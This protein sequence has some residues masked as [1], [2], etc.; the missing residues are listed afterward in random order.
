MFQV[1]GFFLAL[2]IVTGALVA[3]KIAVQENLSIKSISL[4]DLLPWLLIPGLIGARVYHVIDYWNYYGQF[5]QEIFYFWQG[6]L[7]IFGALAGGALGMFFFAR[8]QKMGKKQLLSLLDISGI[9]LSLG[10]SIG[11]WGNFFNQELYGQPTSLPWGIYIKPE[12]RL[13]EVAGF[14]FFHPLFFYESIL[15]L[16]IFLVLYYLLK[17]KT[18][19]HKGSLFFLYLGLYS[20]GRFLLEFLRIR[21]WIIMGI[22]VNQVVSLLLIVASF[23]FIF[24]N[25]QK[26]QS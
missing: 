19:K 3:K 25:S 21:S 23:L 17:E 4:S 24:K 26:K 1:Y 15:G 2:G 8:Q 7:G 10:H 5:P 11:R 13:E 16:I 6:G 18:F 14:S 9:G 22:R 12:N 20:L